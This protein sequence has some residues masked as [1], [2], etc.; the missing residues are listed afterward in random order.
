VSPLGLRSR[1]V[2]LPEGERPAT[3]WLRHGRI[4]GI[5]GYDDSAGSDGSSVP[6]LGDLA[7]L[8]GLVDTH[9]H[10]N[11]PGRTHWEGFASA[12]RA[13]AAGGVTTIV[14]M[15]LN[16][17]P[18]TISV[19]SLD[20]KRRAA[21]RCC[22]DV[23][24]WGGAVPGNAGDLAALHRAGVVGFKCFLADSGVAEF[25]P[26]DRRGLAQALRAVPGALFAVHAE[27]P[28]AIR[29]LRSSR[30]YLDFLASRPDEA[31]C[32][33]VAV[34]IEEARRHGARVHILHLSSGAALPLLHAAQRDGVRVS[35]ETCPHY[36]ALTAEEVPDGATEFKCCPPVR[37]AA[38]QAAL[39][40]A[41]SSGVLHCVVSD[42]SPCEPA[43]KSPGAGDFAVAWGGI[44]SIQLGLSIVWTAACRRGFGLA[45]V[46]RWMAQHPADLAG[47]PT[48]GRIAPGADADLIAFD[49]DADFVVD[50][51]RLH[52]RHPV[53]PYA[54][55]RLR[56]VVRGVWLRGEP[57]DESRPRGRLLSRAGPSDE[58]AAP[59][60]ERAAPSDD[61]PGRR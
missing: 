53:T 34:V 23:G 50:P 28:A 31:E 38:N 39:W 55:R 45:D 1:R 33:A 2:L 47:L 19:R 21:A 17:I 22:T 5:A 44:S 37:G 58:R 40:D 29:P 27:D 4:A 42:H 56:G 51:L 48:K 8:P 25:P 6:D 46:A 14:D 52:H 32:A 36:L 16:S 35:A 59:S 7:L 61:A 18:P 20:T 26:L 9:V 54:G 3:V 10:V 57:V 15:P 41:L 60:D 13:A 43:L 12:T 24:F 30:R 49:P 11:E